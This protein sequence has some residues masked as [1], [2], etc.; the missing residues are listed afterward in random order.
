MIMIFDSLVLPTLCIGN[1]L[2]SFDLII[3]WQRIID[4]YINVTLKYVLV[5]ELY[6]VHEWETEFG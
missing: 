5:A 3:F 6:W 2:H 1:S 4:N